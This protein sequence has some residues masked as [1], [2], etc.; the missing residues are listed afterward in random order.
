MNKPHLKLVGTE[1]VPAARPLPPAVAEARKKH[2]KPFAHEPGSDYKPHEVPVLT[3]WMQ[4]GG[5]KRE[6]SK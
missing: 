6:A 3:R 1:V 4:S 2:G 5:A